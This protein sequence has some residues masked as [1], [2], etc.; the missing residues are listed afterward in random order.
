MKKKIALITGASG[1]IGKSISK[2]LIR[3]GIYV[4]GTT[5]TRN[6][7]KKLNKTFKKKG[8]G[9]IINFLKISIIKKKI[10]KIIKKFHTIDIFIH[11]A[12]I[13]NDSLLI[14]MKDTEWNNVININLSTIFYIT[15]ILL[16]NMIK[17]RYGRIIIISSII[18]SL[19][20]SGQTN[21]AAS[22]SGL[23]G[24]SKSLAIEVASKGITVNV[25]SPGYIMT[26]MTKKFL[27]A[28]KKNIL[29]KIPVGF[30][31]RTKDIAYVVSFLSSKK[32]SYITGQNI[33]VNGG[34]YIDLNT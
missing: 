21:Y 12:G 14:T 6:G 11:N 19:G 13:I 7:L 17:N 34:M 29:K 8:T 30:L 10:K 28:N 25:V 3:K 15:K 26:N 20:Q 32:S 27:L 33:H 24:F 23:I 9:V 2:E 31:G 4:I 16:P 22:K 1:G 18:G 5:T